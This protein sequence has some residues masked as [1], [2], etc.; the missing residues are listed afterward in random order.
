MTNKKDDSVYFFSGA[1]RKTD[2]E[3]NLN[4]NGKILSEYPAW[5]HKAA[6]EDLK[7]EIQQGE[8]NIHRYKRNKIFDSESLYKQDRN[9]EAKKKKLEIIEASRPKLTGKQRDDYYR[10]YNRLGSEIKNYLFTKSEMTMGTANANEEAD[11]IVNPSDIKISPEVAK[12]LNLKTTSDGRISRGQAEKGW[13]TLGSFFHENTNVESLRKDR[14]TAR[15][16]R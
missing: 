6:I 7:E 12:S 16:G 8:R 1:D 13:K 9:L 3:G 14:I 11:R 2:Q 15:A 10:E 4:P 5:M